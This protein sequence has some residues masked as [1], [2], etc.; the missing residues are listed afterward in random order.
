ML[1]LLQL[2]VRSPVQTARGPRSATPAPG[3]ISVCMVEGQPTR[4]T[5]DFP[6]LMQFSSLMLGQARGVAGETERSLARHLGCCKLQWQ[7]L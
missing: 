2:R 5:K 3:Q 7:A 1:V 6:I 4:L